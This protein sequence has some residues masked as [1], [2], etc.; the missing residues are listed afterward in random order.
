MNFR[1]I[2]MIREAYQSSGSNTKLEWA[3]GRPQIKDCLNL[4]LKH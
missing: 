1:V 4:G 3:K 2:G